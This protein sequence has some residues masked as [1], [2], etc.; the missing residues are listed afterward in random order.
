MFAVRMGAAPNGTWHGRAPLPAPQFG[1]HPQ[2][3]IIA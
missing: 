2:S 1:G 3:V